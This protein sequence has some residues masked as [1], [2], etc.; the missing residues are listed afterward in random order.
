[1]PSNVCGMEVVARISKE[2]RR[3]MLFMF[4]MIF[5][6]AGWF[7]Y[8]GFILWPDEAQRY[9]EYSE[10][11]D[12]MIESGDAKDEESSSL[13]LAWQ[14]HARESGYRSNVPKE[15]TDA[16]IR[17]QR[18]IGWVMMGGALLFGAW[19]AWNHTRQVQAKGETV[20]GVSG[21]RV[22]LDSIV[23]MDRKKWKNKGIAYAIYEDAGGKQRRLCL[24]EHKFKGC[25]AIILE[26]EKRIKARSS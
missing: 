23:A 25:E 18:V 19:I 26:A 17:E 24:D 4:F 12:S 20:I 5:G 8:D 11:K 16:A 9:A 10:I 15:R 13:K 22:A 21:Q 3:R 14:R 7:L 1:M 6:I 2:W